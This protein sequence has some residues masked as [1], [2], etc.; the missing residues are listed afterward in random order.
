M[1]RKSAIAAL[2]A[3]AIFASGAQASDWAA[4]QLK[5]MDAYGFGA[6]VD[7]MT[8]EGSVATGQS[9]KVDIVVPAAGKYALVGSCGEDCTDIG[10]ILDQGGKT[11]AQG[12]TG[13]RVELAPGSYSLL[14]G[15][16]NCKSAQCRYVVRAYQS[17]P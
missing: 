7:G 8:W 14:V 1:F 5:E 10:L 2:A 4:S 11:L 13:F 3:A 9:G 16:D 17:K 12:V 15:F 6:A